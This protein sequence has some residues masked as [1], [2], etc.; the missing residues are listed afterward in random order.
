MVEKDAVHRAADGF[1]AAKAERQVGKPARIMDMRAQDAQLLHRLDEVD[2]VIVML[3]DAGGDGEDIGI[4]DDVL[5][6][7]A[8][9]VSSS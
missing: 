8:D 3:L 4:E 5:G 7:K 2:A 1:V 9:A 6:R